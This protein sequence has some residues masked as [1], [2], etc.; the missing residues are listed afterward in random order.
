MRNWPFYRAQ[1]S[2]VGDVMP[3]FFNGRFYTYYLRFVKRDGVGLNEWS[4]R[5]TTDF[6]HF[7]ED[8]RVGIFGGTG[9]V[10]PLDG[11]YHLFK[12]VEPNVIGHY[13]GDTP[14]AFEDTGLRLPSDDEIYV[15]WAWRDPKIFWVEQEQCY[16]MLVATNQKTDSGVCRN[17]CVGLCKSPDL[18][19]WEYCKPM[20]SPLAHDGTYEC[21]DM[22][23]MGE[24]YYLVFSNAN[25]NKLTH[26][27]KSRSLYG[28]WE[29]PNDDTIDSFLFYAGRTACDGENRY[30]AAWNPERTGEDLAMKLGLQDVDQTPM[31][32]FEDMAPF[33]YAGDMVI[34]KL[35]QRDNG[36]LTCEPVPMV[37][38]QFTKSVPFAFRPLQGARW[39]VSAQSAC[40]SS[41]GKYSCALAQKLPRCFHAKIRLKVDGY[42][43]GIALGADAAFYGK[44]LFLRFRPSEGRVNV[45]TALRDKPYIGY[46]LPFAVEQEKFVQ[47]DTE[48]YYNVQIV[49]DGEL[50]VL[51]ING[52]A[53]SLRSKNAVGG[54][55]GFYAYDSE[56]SISQIKVKTTNEEEQE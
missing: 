38:E 6:V 53:L 39:E 13:I 16:W 45:V 15:K 48:G 41:H 55:L 35:G 32:Q 24:W 19:H 25:Y 20:Y 17:G 40:T 22:F 46:C 50:I 4:V 18:Y 47:K 56:I 26:Y 28:P 8:R 11:K 42:E 2:K 52:V 7:S 14:Y 37:V 36:D 54:C 49:Q 1:D 5:E 29:T 31:F 43:A 12:E 23:Q 33:G 21:P 27:V 30:I 44:G 51:Y 9:E 34:H 10:Y 3:C